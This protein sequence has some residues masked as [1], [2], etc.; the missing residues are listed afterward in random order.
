MANTTYTIAMSRDLRCVAGEVFR[1]VE[2]I[3]RFP[4][5]MPSVTAITVLESS[6]ERKVA[7]WETLIDGT[8]LSWTEE[9]VYDKKNLVVQ[10]RSLE[11]IFDRFDGY[12]RVEPVGSGSRVSFELM[13]EIGLPEIEDLIGPM[14][15][16]RLLENAESMMAAIDA[17]TEG[18]K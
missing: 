18:L 5:F 14:L 1:I 16:D 15:R 7:N 13:Y 11:G 6:P 8:P 12:W 17:R 2:D 4:E 9:G 3:E 10:F